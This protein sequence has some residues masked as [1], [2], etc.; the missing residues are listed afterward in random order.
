MKRCFSMFDGKNLAPAADGIFLAGA[1]AAQVSGCAAC[2]AGDEICI[3]ADVREFLYPQI[4]LP[5]VHRVC[6]TLH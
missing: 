6:L 3:K 5:I 1:P 4:M 2:C